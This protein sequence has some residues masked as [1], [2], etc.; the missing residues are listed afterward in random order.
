MNV[1]RF[2]TALKKVV[3]MLNNISTSNAGSLST[4]ISGFKRNGKKNTKS[5]TCMVE[6]LLEVC[7]I[8]SGR[9]FILTDL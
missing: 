2:G 4:N 7:V 5:D 3:D 6:E 8:I 1:F 9:L